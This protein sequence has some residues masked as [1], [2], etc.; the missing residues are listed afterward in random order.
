MKTIKIIA[1]LAALGLVATQA[2]AAIEDG[3]PKGRE[4]RARVVAGTDVRQKFE[5][6]SGKAA[7]AAN[8]VTS[9]KEDRN[10]VREQRDLVYTGKNPLRDSQKQFEI[11]PVK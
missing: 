4:M 8:T 1:L 6:R 10:L 3:S 11:A 7:Y 2:K 5:Y 9:G